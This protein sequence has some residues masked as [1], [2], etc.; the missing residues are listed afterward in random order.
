MTDVLVIGE[1]LIEFLA[2]KSLRE[3]T[4]FNLSFSGDALNSAAAAAA[5]GANTSLVTRLGSD[6]LSDRLLERLELLGINT[7]FVRRDDAHTGAY[8]L[9]AAPEGD[10][11][12]VYLR[13]G[14]A[15]SH[16]QPTDLDGVGLERAHVVLLS[17]I[18]MAL[19]E[20]CS[21]TVLVAAEW[22]GREGARVV[23]DPN[24]RSRLTSAEDA[25]EKL[26]RIA[27]HVDVMI[28]SAPAESE[29][30]FGT[31]DPHLVAERCIELGAKAA[32]VTKGAKG[33]LLYDGAAFSEIE[34]VP[35]AGIVD[36]TG[37]GDVFAGTL[38]A[39]L[40]REAL[41]PSL[42]RLACAAASL[43]LSTPGGAG[44]LPSLEESKAHLAASTR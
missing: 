31:G 28:P 10:R 33:A 23:Y 8:V 6:E 41:S 32:V 18:T 4:E 11:E 36:A 25:R 34:P 3:A 27:P 19:S 15:A 24:F 38:A 22:A 13:T 1:P 39:G 9:G 16:M 26:A 14:S 44:K 12:F 21:R 30:L 42:V 29:V 35:P 40:S 17:G 37:A 5:A 2:L 43:S 7:A 20:S